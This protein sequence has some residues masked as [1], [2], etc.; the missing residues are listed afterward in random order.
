MNIFD[1][2][3]VQIGDY[4]DGFY[5]DEQYEI[6]KAV[7]SL[8]G[9]DIRKDDFYSVDRQVRDQIIEC[10]DSHSNTCT[11]EDYVNGLCESDWRVKED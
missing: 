9:F 5:P 11:W 10:C 1:N 8:P 6:Y 3:R 7:T 2:I 4:I